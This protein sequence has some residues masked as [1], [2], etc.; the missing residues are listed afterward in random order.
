MHVYFSD[1]ASLRASYNPY[2]KYFGAENELMP[3][4]ISTPRNVELCGSAS[5]RKIFLRVVSPLHL[6]PGREID[7]ISGSFLAPR[8]CGSVVR[9]YKFARSSKVIDVHFAAELH[10]EAITAPHYRPSQ[11]RLSF[12]SDCM[13]NL[14]TA[15]SRVRFEIHSGD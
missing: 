10:G 1:L 15:G 2:C 4:S 9:S 5:S 8:V 7:V 3:I 12:V 14:L 13:Q 6:V 11:P